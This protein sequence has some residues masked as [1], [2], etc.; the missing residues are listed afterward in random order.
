[1][2][3][4]ARSGIASVVVLGLMA[5]AALVAAAGLFVV[6]FLVG[7][8]A[9]PAVPAAAR[10]YVWD[11]VVLGFLFF[12]MAG[13]MA[14]LQ[15][16][17]AL[18]LEKFLHL[19]VS[20]AGA[21]LVNYLSSLVS[22]NLLLFVPAAVGLA[23]GQSFGIGALSLVLLPL[24]AAFL[25]AVTALTYQFQGWLAGLMTNPRRR[26]TVVVV[27]MMAFVLIAQAPSLVSAA[28]GRGMTKQTEVL[29]E[30]MERRQELQRWIA[31]RQGE[32]LQAQQKKEITPEEA[33]RRNAEVYQQYRARQEAMDR[34][35]KD[36][37][38][39]RD[40]SAEER[41]AQTARVLNLA[42]PPGWLAL[43]AA[44]L[45][46]GDVVPA[47]LATLAF[48]MIGVASLRRGYRSTV[49]MYTGNSGSGESKAARAEGPS[50]DRTRV[51]MVEW[52]L[53]W[54]SEHVSAVAA[55]ALR[56][57]IRAPEAKMMLL[58]PVI[59]VLLLSTV[60]LTTK[61]DVPEA[62]RPLIATGA[63]SFVLLMAA[64][65]IGNQFGYDR[66]GFRVYVLSPAP[67]RDL[68][69]GKN[70][71]AAPLTLGLGV[72]I[73]ILVECVFPMRVDHLLA[74]AL[75]LVSMYLVFCLLANA[76]S[77]FA[78]VPLAP[79]AMQPSTMRG[80]PLLL[81]MGFVMC[82]PLALAPTLVPLGVE[83]LLAELA[84]V[85]GWPVALVL[86]ALLLAGMVWVYRSVV[87]WE[88]ALLAAREQAILE[89]VTSKAE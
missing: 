71:A 28:F 11:G 45:G 72:L 30:Q 31:E 74:V 79:G 80:L 61:A 59:L 88:G 50:P 6:G 9:M 52:R 84:G 58:S 35:L 67:R 16:T 81:H 36:E 7:L 40:R 44:G 32:V 77:I 17:E 8:L 66:G 10:L 15:R 24:L 21:F 39:A 63:A 18:S 14:D 76:L 23:L 29:T 87:A 5:V 37:R 65:L 82:F 49:R 89:V 27:V 20:P 47:L 3:Q 48:T 26:R 73:L 54:V 42:L 51:P 75:Q 1:V 57:L 83:V 41:I 46:A 13:L 2:N 25:L 38:A 56:S 53:P 64:Q 69:V 19:P 34:E 86:S 68:L 43:G 33:K 62:F 12:W 4:L 70:L 55:A 78:P 85:R 60:A 22:F